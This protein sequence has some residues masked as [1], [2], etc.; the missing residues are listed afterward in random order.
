M[1]RE[2]KLNL[3]QSEQFYYDEESKT[4]KPLAQNGAIP[5]VMVGGG[6]IGGGNGMRFLNGE[7]APVNDGNAMEG[8][9]YLDVLN[10]DLYKKTSE[11]SKIMNLKGA[12][13]ATGKDGINGKDGAKGETGADGKSAYQIWLDEGNVGT[14]QDFITSLKGVKGDKGETGANGKDGFGTE[15]QYNAI[16][17]ELEEIKSRLDEPTE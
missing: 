15:A 8:D 11:W 6:S 2:T 3:P 14:E 13:G 5:V 16:I 7:G 10:G 4:F 17:A 9:I 12:D 1:A